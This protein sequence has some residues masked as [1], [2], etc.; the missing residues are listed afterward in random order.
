MMLK[1]I[2]YP[3][4][5][6]FTRSEEVKVFDEELHTFLDDMYETMISS[7]GIG[8]AA[9]QVAKPLR[10]FLINLLN[11]NEEQNKDDLIEFIN[12]IITP[13]GEGTQVYEEGCLSV[14]GFFEEVTRYNKIKVD[15]LDRFGN[16]K[17]LEAEGLLAVAIQHENDHLDGHLFIEKISFSGRKKLEKHL[18]SSKKP[19]K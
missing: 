4:K 2:T 1:L 14:P 19:K 17:T 8:L 18:K 10:I 12:P 11:E 7:S 16:Q 6:L 3:N 15:Y 13:I 5:L 9:I